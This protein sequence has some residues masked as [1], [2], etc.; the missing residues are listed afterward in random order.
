MFDRFLSVYPLRPAPG[1]LELRT[2]ESISEEDAIE[3][4]GR[5]LDLEERAQRQ[6]S[7][8][9]RSTPIPI[10]RLITESS[11]R[12]FLDDFGVLKRLS[13][14]EYETL[15]ESFDPRR[16]GYAQ[17]LHAFFVHE[18]ERRFF[19]P[20]AP[21]IAGTALERL[22]SA[23][24]ETEPL[25]IG[26]PPSDNAMSSD[27]LLHVKL[28]F[29][30]DPKPQ[31]TFVLIFAAAL[32]LSALLSG[33]TL[34]Y[35]LL[36][37]V[38]LPLALA[39]TAYMPCAA[40]LVFLE[41]LK[42]LLHYEKRL[43]ILDLRK[44]VRVFIALVFF[45]LYWL[46][47]LRSRIPLTLGALVLL[48]VCLVSA[49]SSF[50][51][52]QA[53]KGES[54]AL[55]PR[56]FDPSI[57]PRFVLPFALGLAASLLYPAFIEGDNIRESVLEAHT[58]AAAQSALISSEDYRVHALFQKYFSFLPLGTAS[59]IFK[60]DAS[61]RAQPA[62]YLRYYLGSDGLIAGAQAEPNWAQFSDIPPFPLQELI[63]YFN[64]FVHTATEP[65]PLD[66]IGTFDYVPPLAVFVAGVPF[67]LYALVVWSKRKKSMMI[68]TSRR[69]A[70]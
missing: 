19:I 16:D 25:A 40:L 65:A 29:F 42:T 69:V 51:F 46:L 48:S 13:L 44:G 35:A 41:L 63:D 31:W 53:K 39:G 36:L 57:F 24:L 14:R 34:R 4:F 17:K 28:V 58:E 43:F 30:G 22:S 9:F 23:L 2:A 15:V 67:A 52:V 5:A 7:F 6:P 12:L 37:P 61:S 45:A 1:W 50:T 11:Q 49:I 56:P 64:D 66:R 59:E 26:R 54:L 33:H 18:G 20:F 62:P 70:A 32:L 8:L 47:L 38:L 60:K 10:E 3:W 68:P 55:E 21:D 27:S